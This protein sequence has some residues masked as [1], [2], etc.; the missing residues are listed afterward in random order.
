MEVAKAAVDASKAADAAM[1]K[2]VAVT[3]AANEAEWT[4]L[5]AAAVAAVNNKKQQRPPPMK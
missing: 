2:M 4:R 5:V 1:V 3:A